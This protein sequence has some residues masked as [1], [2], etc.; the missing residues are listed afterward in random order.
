MTKKQKSP[1]KKGD[2]RL[3]AEVDPSW[4]TTDLGTYGFGY[5]NAGDLLAR[6][7]INAIT[8]KWKDWRL[9]EENLEWLVGDV[10][11]D[12]LIFPLLGLYRQGT[13]LML[14][15]F[16][17][18]RPGAEDFD[19]AAK[20]HNLEKLWAQAKEHLLLLGLKN[21]SYE[22]SKIDAFIK[23]LHEL[24]PKG[25]AVRFPTDYSRKAFFRD[26]EPLN[27]E[28]IFQEAREVREVFEGL[29]EWRHEIWSESVE[30]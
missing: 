16:I 24:D 9:D 5:F 26:H 6:T 30:G 4:T 27:I 18:D 22:V 17:Y 8:G 11:P 25:E 10:Y 20:K 15:H 7:I 14:K 13:E 2:A 29:A 23:K 19:E 1:F 12:T 28:A 21:E 3:K